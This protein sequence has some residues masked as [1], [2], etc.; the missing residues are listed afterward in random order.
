MCVYIMANKWKI[1][2]K[3]TPLSHVRHTGKSVWIPTNTKT[4]D[5]RAIRK[6]INKEA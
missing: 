3:K 6:R 1:K 4:A 2:E 5:Y